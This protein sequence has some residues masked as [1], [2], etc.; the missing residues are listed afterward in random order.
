[1]RQQR[2]STDH[3]LVIMRLIVADSKPTDNNSR[4]L[5]G[6]NTKSSEYSLSK[7]EFLNL[8]NVDFDVV[9]A[10]QKREG[11]TQTI[12][13]NTSGPII[14]I[15]EFVN[16]N[17]ASTVVV[18]SN[19]ALFYANGASLNILD[20]GWS[21]GQP[22]DMLTFVNREW[23]ANGSK[24]YGWSGIGATPMPAGLPCSTSGLSNMF[25]NQASNNASYW[26]VGGATHMTH[27]SSFT[28]RGLYLAYSFV[29][30]DGYYGPADFLMNAKNIV[31]GTQINPD[32]NGDEWLE[33][34][35][36]GP[37]NNVSGFT[38]PTGLGISSIAVWLAVDTVTVASTPENIPGVGARRTGVLGWDN[39]NVGVN[40]QMSVTLKPGADLARFHLYTL[41]S[42]SN[43]F[44]VNNASGSTGWAFTLFPLTFSAYSS[45][46][47]IGYAFTGNPFCWFDTNT[48][49]Y[50]DVNQNSMFMAG[51]SNS[52]SNVWFSDIGLPET[53]Q[54]ENFFEVRTNDGDRV[55]AIKAFNNTLIV[56][57][58]NSFHKVIGDS[59]DNFELIELSGEYGCISNN[60][61]IEYQEKLVW[62]DQKGIVQYNG[63]SWSV[64]STQVEDI[65]RRMNLTAAK[66]KACAIHHLYRNQVWFGIPIDG[67]TENN[68]T[69]V[70]D[71]LVD[72]WTF[73]DGFSPSSF[74]YVK[75]ELTRPTVWRGDYSGMIYQHSASFL[76]DN[77]VAISCIWT[78]HWDKNKEN[79]SWIWRRSFLDVNTVSGITGQIT[80]K[81]Y[82]DYNLST[83]QATFAM[84]QSAFQS[85]AEMGVV[86]KAVTAEFAH[87]SASL[88]L[89]INN[90]SWAKR[91][92]RNV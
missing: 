48:P 62:L 37:F 16:L 70:Y 26:L 11:S 86:G 42:P 43:L 81:V 13:A 30:Q 56:L 87:R 17:G 31:A 1:M 85:R 8:R 52:P 12:G 14:G 76:G 74:A 18:A 64:I 10:I 80:A 61:V 41:M 5:G 20:T 69:V 24:F 23:M 68:I 58:Q 35:D 66:E 78:P 4:M 83:V 77:G 27:S 51:F 38:V 54:P 63:A 50:I 44:L 79:E 25:I 19:Q 34:V 6:I 75:A 65:F 57:K 90:Y 89:L 92:L 55:Y 9:N 45:L 67:S 84:Y 7:S 36:T 46:P 15:H 73:F 33:V 2:G 49:K 40:R 28:L 82:S 3:T 21:N 53:I 22:P 60:T 91:F 32:A 39:P 72:A 88:P 71:Y 59:P 47:G 29:R